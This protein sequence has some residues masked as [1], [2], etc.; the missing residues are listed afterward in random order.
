MRPGPL[1]TL[2][3]QRGMTLVSLMVGLLLGLLSTVA[4]MTLFRTVVQNS[5]SAGTDLA[6]DTMV[7]SALL[8]AQ[9]E[10]H[11]AG[12]GFEPADAHDRLRLYASASLNGST[13]SGS[14]VAIDP[15]QKSGNALLWQWFDPDASASEEEESGAGVFR[16]AGLIAT[17]GGLRLLENGDCP[18][19][20]SPTS[21]SWSTTTLIPDGRLD[22]NGGVQFAARD[23]LCSPYGKDQNGRGVLLTMS[24]SNSTATLRSEYSLCLPNI[25]PLQP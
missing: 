9:L 7:S 4:A 17:S 18:D 1:P 22:E 19:F 14:P 25:S 2:R 3:H 20:A 21:I 8:R 15:V 16:C 6:Q 23:D 5:V 10:V 13:V 12:Y 11:N 24:A